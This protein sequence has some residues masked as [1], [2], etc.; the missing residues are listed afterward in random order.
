MMTVQSSEK[1]RLTATSPDHRVE[2]LVPLAVGRPYSYLAGDLSLSAGDF[3]TVPLG[4]RQTLGV[5]WD[6]TQQNK[7]IPAH[8]LKS[9]LHRHACPPMPEMHRKFLSWIAGY[10]MADLGSVLK[11]TLTTAAGIA[12]EQGTP[13][14]RAADISPDGLSPKRK[15]VYEAAQNA[16]DLTAKSLAAKAGSTP[17]LVK[18][19]AADGQLTVIARAAPLPCTEITHLKTDLDLSNDQAEASKVL[20]RALSDGGFAPVL[21]DGV[22]GSGKTEVYFEALAEAFRLGKQVLVLLPE[23]GLSS[24]F[25]SRFERRFGVKPAVWHSEITPAQK[26]KIWRGVIEGRT[27]CVVGARSALFLPFAD[28]GLIVVDEEHDA[29]YKQEDGVIYNARDMAVVRA[30]IGAFPVVLASATPSLETMQN[31]WAGKYT[32]VT[33]TS[34]FGAAV[35]PEI[36]MIDMRSEKTT[37]QTF[38][39]E[40]L[41]AAMQERVERGEQSLLFLNRRGY[42]PLT[43]CRKC[44]HRIECPSCTAWLVEHR[45]TGNLHCHHCGFQRKL[46]KICPECEAEESLVACG[47]GVERIAEEVYAFLLDANILVLSS[48]ITNSPKALNDAISAIAC[49]DIDVIIGT[50]MIAKGH[51]FPKLTCVGVIDAD[52]GLGGADMRAAERTFQ[53]LHQVSGRAG[54]ADLPGQVF[55]QSYMPDHAVMKALAAGARDPFLKIESEER[56]EASMPPYGKLVALIVSGNK[57]D[58]VKA[59]CRDLAR[60][61][62]AYS[63]VQVLGPA[64]AMLSMLRGKHRWRF[65]I[66]AEKEAQIQKIMQDWVGAVKKPSSVQLKIDID[67]QS[68]F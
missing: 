55:L 30:K 53:L 42:A 32:H 61:A 52:V 49:G 31:V 10:T 15:A 26:R 33:L 50:Q 67:P 62:P 46:P 14:Y 56:A 58:Q 60:T 47:P 27:K 22:T 20:T 65:L 35:L 54:R 37:A 44:A 57:E 11:L 28:L 19:M 51:N 43:L 1:H 64:A 68:F 6:D 24:Q 8:K 3:V 63:N 38:I 16:P 4:R 40:P 5:V 18:S 29:S 48:D 13:R 45:K 41:R 17:A 9:V 21:L 36:H 2:V 34:R 7:D 59:Y 66:K 25:I 23:I 39:S 12:P